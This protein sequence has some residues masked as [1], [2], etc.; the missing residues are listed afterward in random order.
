MRNRKPSRP[1]AVKWKW[2]LP[3]SDVPDSWIRG[4]FS[5]QRPMLAEGR[6]PAREKFPPDPKAGGVEGQGHSRWEIR[7]GW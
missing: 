5:S 3:S 2:P 4:G 6:L 7:A 1:V